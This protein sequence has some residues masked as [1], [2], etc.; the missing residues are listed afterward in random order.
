MTDRHPDPNCRQLRELQRRLGLLLEAEE[1]RR[2]Y[3]IFFDYC[4]FP[5]YPRTQAEDLIFLNDIALLRACFR[6]ADHVIILSEG[7][8]EYK[9]RAWCFLEAI[10]SETRLHFFD[11]QEHIRADLAFLNYLLDEGPQLTSFDFG[12]KVHLNEAE[13]ITATFQHLASCSATH[14]E[15]IR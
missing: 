11:D 15:D 3:L 1:D 6:N 8:A 14:Y 10:V 4:A 12:Y 13:I 7:Y 2:E 5:Q 9:D